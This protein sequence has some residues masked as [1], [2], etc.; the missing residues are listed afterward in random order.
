[1]KTL[2]MV[3]AMIATLATSPVLGADSVPVKITVQDAVSLFNALSSL[4]GKVRP[5]PDGKTYTDPYSFPPQTRMAIARNLLVSKSIVETYQEA[6]KGLLKEYNVD[7]KPITNKDPK[8]EEFVLKNDTM[9]K[10]EQTVNFVMINL[11]D[12]NLAAN[13][14][15]GSAIASLAPVIANFDDANVTAP[16]TPPATTVPEPTHPA[17]PS[18]S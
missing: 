6:R 13:A 1:M 15:P 2:A 12:L 17:P 9:F 8:W 10:E 5:G 14:I 16:E 7:G 3:V 11:D 18:K 4:D